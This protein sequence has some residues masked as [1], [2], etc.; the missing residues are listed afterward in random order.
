MPLGRVEAKPEATDAYPS[1]RLSVSSWSSSCR[2]GRR[3]GRAGLCVW[4]RRQQWQ[5]ERGGM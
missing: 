3:R 5:R 4:Q 2:A 1:A